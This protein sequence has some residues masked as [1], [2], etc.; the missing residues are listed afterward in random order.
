MNQSNLTND[1]EL[2][3]EV[4][5]LVWRE[6]ESLLA[7]KAVHGTPLWLA[8]QTELARDLRQHWE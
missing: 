3:R 4:D 5:G 7:L 1:C 6:S 2:E 8:D